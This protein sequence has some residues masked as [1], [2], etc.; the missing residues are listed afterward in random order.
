MR[1]PF[2]IANFRLCLPV[3]YAVLALMSQYHQFYKIGFNMAANDSF[4]FWSLDGALSN[5]SW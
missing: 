4:F 2:P 1:P 5:R 3:A